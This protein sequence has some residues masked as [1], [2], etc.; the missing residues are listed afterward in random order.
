MFQGNANGAVCCAQPTATLRPPVDFSSLSLFNPSLNPI[1]VLLGLLSILCRVPVGRAGSWK[2]SSYLHSRFGGD[3]GRSAK[4][5]LC[6]L[7]LL[8]SQIG[9]KIPAGGRE[10]GIDLQELVR[11]W[12]PGR[13]T[14]S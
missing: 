8:W 7:A 12:P 1:F 3:R 11:G 4:G 13:D 5:F 6:Q 9:T 2:N 10:G 14:L